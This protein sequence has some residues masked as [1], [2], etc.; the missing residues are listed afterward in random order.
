MSDSPNGIGLKTP[1]E[2]VKKFQ[3]WSQLRDF[4]TVSP[5]GVRENR[6]LPAL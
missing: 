1:T 4:L 5:D 2:L 3:R 6:H